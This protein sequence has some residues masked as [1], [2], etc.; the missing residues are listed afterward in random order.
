M[1]VREHGRIFLSKVGADSSRVCTDGI[2]TA[3]KSLKKG[4]KKYPC[5]TG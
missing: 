3:E 4:K 5:A 1:A 2:C